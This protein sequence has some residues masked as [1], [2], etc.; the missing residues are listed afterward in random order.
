MEIKMYRCEITGKISKPG[1]P[2]NKIVVET[3][4]K[5]YTRWIK[6]E[7]TRLFEEKIVG[8]GFETVKELCVSLEGEALWNSWSAEERSDFL[9]GL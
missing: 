5:N 3:R 8:Q 9:K 4:P 7:D 6:N 2:L 1:Q